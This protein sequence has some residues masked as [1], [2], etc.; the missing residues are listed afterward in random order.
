MIVTL[1]SNHF[2]F[3]LFNSSVHKTMD[4]HGGSSRRGSKGHGMEGESSNQQ[5]KLSVKVFLPAAFIP[6]IWDVICQRGR[7]GYDHSE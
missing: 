4:Q 3:D 2:T 7:E 5:D 6:G 1:T